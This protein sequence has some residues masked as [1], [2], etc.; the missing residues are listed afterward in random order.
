M[1]PIGWKAKETKYGNI[2]KKQ[3]KMNFKMGINDRFIDLD[4]K[5]YNELEKINWDGNTPVYSQS[6]CSYFSTME[7][8]EDFIKKENIEYDDLCLV[9]CVPQFITP[10]DESWFIDDLPEDEEYQIPNKLVYAIKAFNSS[11]KDVII[12]YI[13]GDRAIIK[14]EN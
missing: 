12:S 6:L 1:I 4:K 9:E 10:I 3:E 13:P 7:E 8:V 11:I 14:N 5:F 2:D